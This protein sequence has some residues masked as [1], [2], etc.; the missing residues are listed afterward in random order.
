M[1]RLKPQQESREKSRYILRVVQA[2]HAATSARM[3]ASMRRIGFWYESA[4]SNAFSWLARRHTGRRQQSRAPAPIEREGDEIGH[5]G[6]GGKFEH[7]DYQSK[8]EHAAPA[9]LQVDR[10][11]Q[12]HPV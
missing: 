2:S 4:I 1:I 12:T 7:Q 11:R 9:L 5:I 3:V 6:P 10:R 8:F